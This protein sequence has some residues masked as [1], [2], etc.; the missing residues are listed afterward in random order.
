VPVSIGTNIS[1]KKT[2]IK[3]EAVYLSKICV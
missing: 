1:L 3:K 2:I